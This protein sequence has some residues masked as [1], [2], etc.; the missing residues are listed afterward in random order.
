MNIYEITLRIVV[1]TILGGVI[2]MEREI[3]DQAA[4]FR[5]HILVCVGATLFTIAS[6][7]GFVGLVQG[8]TITLDPTRIAAQIVSGIGFLGAGAIIRYGVSV[9]GLTTAASLWVVAAIGLAVGAGFY[10]AALVVSLA[11]LVSLIVLRSLEYRW[12]H[13]VKP[14]FQ[15]FSL[16]LQDDVDT[17]SKVLSFLESRGV[18]T[19]EIHL[20]RME[21]D[22]LSLNLVAQLPHRLKAE[23]IMHPLL[24]LEGVF[25]VDMR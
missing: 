21:E 1:A 14:E 11:V 17:V 19:R 9:R 12:L 2:G 3:R 23:D 4:G 13:K 6:Q 20:E 15:R 10:S 8:S 18:T 5:T 25:R 7:Y 22:R 16:C 24:G